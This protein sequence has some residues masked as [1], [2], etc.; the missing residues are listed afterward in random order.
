MTCKAQASS[1]CAIWPFIMEIEARPA[2]E[3]AFWA[4]V[5]AVSSA[6]C[7]KKD[8]PNGKPGHGLLAG[9]MLYFEQIARRLRGCQRRLALEGY[10]YGETSY[11][12]WVQRTPEKDPDHFCSRLDYFVLKNLAEKGPP[13]MPHQAVSFTRFLE[14]AKA[15]L[16]SLLETV[17]ADFAN[18][19]L[20]RKW[21]DE[22]GKSC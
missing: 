12:E 7:R 5:S 17:K 20:I 18:L 4:A 2:P 21:T 19:R 15:L 22:L 13:K 10:A 8:N 14:L 11:T 3:V 6:F 1:A 16:N 9:M